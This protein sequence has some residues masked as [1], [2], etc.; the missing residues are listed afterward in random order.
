MN[1]IA[2]MV[3]LLL[4]L[5][6]ALG[7]GVYF[8]LKRNVVQTSVRAG[9][10]IVSVIV[11]AIIAATLTPTIVSGTLSL[12]KSFFGSE[13]LSY[14]L[15]G[16][17]GA[18]GIL[19]FVYA[20]A[21][22][23]TFFVFFFVI[24]LVCIGIYNVLCRYLITD[25]KLAERA[26]RK[27]ENAP[28]EENPDENA[29]KNAA[30]EEE[31]P[32]VKII[33]VKDAMAEDEASKTPSEGEEGT[34][35]KAT[36]PEENIGE[37]PDTPPEENGE[38][39]NAEADITENNDI[40]AKEQGEAKDKKE[41]EK[42]E[43][44]GL[45]KAA[46][47]AILVA[48]NAIC[49]VILVIALAVPVTSV[50]GAFSGLIEAA[51]GEE[52]AKG[53]IDEINPEEDTSEAKDFISQVQFLS[54]NPVYNIYRVLSVPV[55]YSITG[56]KVGDSALQPLAGAI[57][58]SENLVKSMLDLMAK[59]PYLTAKIT[60]PDYAEVLYDA[61]T[62]VAPAPYWDMLLGNFLSDASSSW[63]DGNLFMGMESPFAVAMDEYDDALEKGIYKTLKENDKASVEFRAVADELCLMSAV[64][65]VDISGF[66]SA[67]AFELLMKNT[68]KESAAIAAKY[69][70]DD[71]LIS[72]GYE[73]DEVS[74]YKQVFLS[75]LD[76]AVSVGEATYSGESEKEAAIS[77][78]ANN[79]TTFLM[80]T[81]DPDGVK[82]ADLV[83]AY[84]GSDIVKRIVEDVTDQ[85]KTNN[86]AGIASS[87]TTYR[88][89]ELKDL[90]I[91]EMGDKQTINYNE[92]SYILAYITE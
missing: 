50:V 32:D 56:V 15:S 78:E 12:F 92:Y 82:N 18:D 65:C 61:S 63:E 29:E 86:P 9:M 54:D 2:L 90:F 53:Y 85:G 16:T 21:A 51:G 76:G 11:S 60:W 77:K 74:F 75:I 7:L 1:G 80:F 72:I 3:I 57:A 71:L 83:S 64:Y 33:S 30:E 81:K 84:A 89:N 14:L 31:L 39:I 5:L 87:L 62:G 38:N 19:S 10:I 73:E 20:I 35:S 44:K 6:A 25:E 66:D 27:K 34:D 67:H 58:S 48:A 45:P 13:S 55:V 69:I 36:Y 88:Y 40:A 47:R 22:P 68:T 49:S 28:A 59:S 24:T 43:K 41:G 17:D 37:N 8:G 52:S 26:A 42:E 91:K 46:K 4:A 70:T 79:I 23:F